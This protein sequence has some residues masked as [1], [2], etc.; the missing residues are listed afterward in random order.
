M[1]TV[2]DDNKKLCLSNGEI[3][4][5]GETMTFIYE[6]DDLSEASPATISRCGMIYVQPGITTS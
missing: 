5:I 4:K 3:I 2:L 6:V 1:N